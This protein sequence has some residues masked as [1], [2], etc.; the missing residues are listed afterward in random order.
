[1]YCDTNSNFCSSDFFKTTC[2]HNSLFSRKLTVLFSNFINSE[3]E[4]KLFGWQLFCNK[5]QW[6]RYN[7]VKL[8]INFEA[9]ESADQNIA[10]F[11]LCLF[12]TEIWAHVRQC[13]CRSKRKWSRERECC[14]MHFRLVSVGATFAH[15]V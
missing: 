4:E 13:S 1:M 3:F 11:F 6:K 8:I 9:S 5:L 7:P 12:L 2:S 14:Q 15:L 10:T